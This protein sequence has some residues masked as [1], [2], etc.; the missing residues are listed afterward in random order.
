MAAA[1]ALL[2]VGVGQSFDRRPGW[3]HCIAA[4]VA[5]SQLAFIVVRRSNAAM[6][7]GG[8]CLDRAEADLVRLLLQIT[9]HSVG[10]V[11]VSRLSADACDVRKF[12]GLSS[13]WTAIHVACSVLLQNVEN[14]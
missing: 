6:L 8:A 9:G 4:R 1:A 5:Q 10:S 3:L 7:S 11:A 14:W 12:D 2:L 13:R